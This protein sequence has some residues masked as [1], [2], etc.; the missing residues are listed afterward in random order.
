MFAGAGLGRGLVLAVPR[1]AAVAVSGGVAPGGSA[2]FL[3]LRLFVRPVVASVGGGAATENR[4]GRGYGRSDS[5]KLHA[6]TC[7]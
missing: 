1:M 6:A 4:K 5:K 7:S 2:L 3:F